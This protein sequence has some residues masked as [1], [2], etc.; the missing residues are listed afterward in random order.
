MI[1]Q[2]R[3]SKIVKEFY[4]MERLRNEDSY[5]MIGAPDKLNTTVLW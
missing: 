3:R 4:E 2:K 5:K 1:R